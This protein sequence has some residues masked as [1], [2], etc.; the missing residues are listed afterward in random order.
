MTRSPTATPGRTLID[1][2]GSMRP[3]LAVR[4]E[5]ALSPFGAVAGHDRLPLTREPKCLCGH[6][7]TV[8]YDHLDHGACPCDG[9]MPVLD[10]PLPGGLR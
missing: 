2:T 6:A 5:Y 3:S 9:Y 1:T 4:L 7:A 8:H 10:L